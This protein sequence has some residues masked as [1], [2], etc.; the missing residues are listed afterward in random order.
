VNIHRISIKQII[1]MVSVVCL[2]LISLI[3]CQPAGSKP[4]TNQKQIAEVKRDSLILSIDADGN[5]SLPKQA[6]LCFDTSGTVKEI[7][8]KK[9]DRVTKGQLLARLDDTTQQMAVD[10]AQTDVTIAKN[11][12]QKRICPSFY[13]GPFEYANTPGVFDTLDEIQREIE[14]AIEL[15][16]G[17][18]YDEAHKE[19][20]LAQGDFDR[21]KRIFFESYVKT[22]THGLDEATLINLTLQLDKAKIAL[23]RAKEDL[24]KTVIIAPF[25]GIV[26]DVGVKEG[27]KLS[28]MNY[29]TTTA[30]YLID[31]TVIEMEGLVDEI[32]VPGVKLGQEAIITVD[33]FPD[34]ELKG[35]VTFVSPVATIQSG[36]VS[37]KVTLNLQYPVNPELMDGMTA[38]AEIIIDRKDNVLL[39]PERAV[40][41]KDKEPWVEV[42]QNGIVQPRKVTLGMTDGRNIEVISGL[43]EGE[44]IIV[45]PARPPVQSFF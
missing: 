25:D 39:I 19:L 41:D 9:G 5:L 30:A 32:D 12:L 6:E 33:A 28:S 38:T 18:K 43:M 10:A 4:D 23:E 45:E 26:A 14:K 17:K 16:E 20:L 29:A 15:M 1:L 40:K 31:P 27:D 3:S 42:V 7:K 11:A 21:A 8:V 24:K 2:V 36:I 44:N 22:Y 37:Y 34:I 35:E 13:A